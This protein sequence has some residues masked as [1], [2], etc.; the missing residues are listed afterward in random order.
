MSNLRRPVG[1]EDFF[2]EE[3]PEIEGRAG[4]PGGEQAAVGHDAFG[5][6]NGGQF[7]GDGGV[8][9]VAATV[10]ETGV[11]EHGG[12]RADCGQPAVSGMVAEN[13]WADALISAEEFYARATGEKK[14]VEERSGGGG[15]AINVLALDADPLR[16]FDRETSDAMVAEVD[17]AHKEGE[18]LGGIVE[19]LAGLQGGCP[20]GA[21]K[22]PVA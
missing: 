17:A 11:V 10:E 12:R 14:A 20:L 4:A 21:A 19:V 22:P 13:K 18:T 16:C 1:T 15:E 8:G 3:Q 6:E 2:D 7:S 5:G 9:R